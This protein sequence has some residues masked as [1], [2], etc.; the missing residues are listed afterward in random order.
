[1]LLSIRIYN[2]LV[3]RED[4]ILKNSRTIKLSIL[5]MLLSLQVKPQVTNDF[6]KAIELF[7]TQQYDAALESFTA[8]EQSD[9]ENH[10][11]H[12][13]LGQIDLIKGDHD[14]ASKRFSTAIE[15]DP[16]NSIYHLWLGKTNIQ[17]LQ[18]ASFFEQGIIANRAKNNFQKAVQYDPSNV[19]A[20]LNLAGYYLNAPAIAGGS[21]KKAIEQAREIIHND[22][23]QGHL[24]LARI[25]AYEEEY[26]QALQ[27]YEVLITID[28]QDEDL[29]YGKGLL[30]QTNK[31]FDKAFEVFEK[32]LALNPI[33]MKNL[34][35]VGRTGVY[36]G[37]NLNRSI[38]CLKIYLDHDPEPG[39]PPA[40][41]AHW[42]LGMLYEKAGQAEQAR[43]EYEKALALNP[44]EKKYKTAL[45]DL[46]D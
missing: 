29:Y 17:K 36:S 9:P 24:M 40:D 43:Q 46:K 16:Q 38:E 42:R 18:S 14:A 37:Q 8:L 41:A 10:K 3:G 28:P 32:A 26:D 12:Y 45:G 21:I 34:Y 22:A 30:L 31:Q 25:Y 19:E 13:F 1:M 6:D 20:R 35:Q 44:K 39:L 5:L 7:E 23:K 2:Y 15:H 27:E 11:L 33:S 4:Q